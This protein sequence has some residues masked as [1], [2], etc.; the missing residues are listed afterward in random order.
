MKKVLALALPLFIS[1][2]AL[3][4]EDVTPRDKSGHTF[5]VGVSKLT[6]DLSDA[7]AGYY[8]HGEVLFDKHDDAI[9]NF[10]YD[11]TTKFGVIFGGYYMPQLMSVSFADLLWI[12]SQ[13]LGFYSGYQFDNNIRLTAGLSFTYTEADLPSLSSDS[14]TNVGF[15]V[16]LEYLAANKFLIGARVTTHEVATIHYDNM[17]NAAYGN[18]TG[19]TIGINIG[20]KF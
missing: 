10:G 11:Y 9:F 20:Y 19:T 8:D 16:G 5:H 6:G 3:A 2:Q 17:A 14:E 4:Y 15:M 13:V 7:I 12:E 1:T 18:V